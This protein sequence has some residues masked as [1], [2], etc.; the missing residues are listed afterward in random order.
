M[1]FTSAKN[2]PRMS[3]QSY[4]A[5]PQLLSADPD[6]VCW[7]ALRDSGSMFCLAL[8]DLGAVCWVVLHDSGSISCLALHDLGAYGC[9]RPDEAAYSRSR[10]ESGAYEENCY[11]SQSICKG[12]G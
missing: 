10:E 4:A 2:T 3:F 1:N 9:R 6:T 7:V 5:G 11:Y 8:R 12:E